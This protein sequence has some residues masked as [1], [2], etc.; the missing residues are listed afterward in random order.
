MLNISDLETPP[1]NVSAFLCLFEQ[2]RM[3]IRLFL[4]VVL[5]TIDQTH[6]IANDGAG[7]LHK[8]ISV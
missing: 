3:E 1:W 4:I 7:N 8:I 2:L 6:F 5:I